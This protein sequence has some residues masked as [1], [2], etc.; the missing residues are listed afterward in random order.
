MRITILGAGAIGK[1]Y[2]AYLSSRGHDV[3]IWSP[4]GR[5]LG[6]LT[7]DGILTA[8]GICEGEFHVR[9]AASAADAVNGAELLVIAVPANGH[10]AVIDAIAPHLVNGQSVIISAEL[11]MSGLLLSREICA[12]GLAVPVI[13]WAT[14][15]VT[16]RTTGPDS[17]NVSL[18]RKR[19]DIAFAPAAASSIAAAM[20]TEVFGV[21]FDSKASLLA[22]T[23]SNL[24][25]PAH[26]AIALCNFTRME[27]GEDW[28]SYG[29]I[30]DGVG[31]L[32]EQLDAERLAL[33]KAFGLEVR[34]VF[35]HYVHSFSVERGPLGAMAQTV[36]LARP[37]VKGPTSLDTRFV[38]E[39]VPF[40]L[41]PLVELG[42]LVGVDMSLHRSGVRIFSALYGTNF[43][44]VNDVLP[45][46]RFSE[47]RKRDLVKMAS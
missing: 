3:A 15:V 38:T 21:S 16:A 34:S 43:E 9:V 44:E 30:T 11:S 6:R 10:T 13:G 46:M 42:K 20:C 27:K 23:L 47:L 22:I 33:A 31:R 7:S 32:M 2:A 24:N 39:D 14:T 37:H 36:A 35:D 8:T 4:S 12:R 1:G 18:L 26:M 28:S 5:N 17:V 19:L 41:F 29:G 40:G 45:K 25:P